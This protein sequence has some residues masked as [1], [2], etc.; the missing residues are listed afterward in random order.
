MTNN[1]LSVQLHD[2]NS[3]MNIV[4]FLFLFMVYLFVRFGRIF[5]LKQI[6]SRLNLESL[7]SVWIPYVFML[8]CQSTLQQFIFHFSFLF[9]QVAQLSWLERK[10][11]ATLF[12]EP[13]TSSVEDALKNFLKVWWLGLVLIHLLSITMSIY[14]W[15]P[16][17]FFIIFWN[18]CRTAFEFS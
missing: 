6:S 4:W 9:L 17:F 14:H 2:S 12:G 15:L 18:P 3:L 5:C 7:W 13:P 1:M 8:F 16:F 10:V 11:A